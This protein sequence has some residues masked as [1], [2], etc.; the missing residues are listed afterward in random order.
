[1]S[2][3]TTVY[4]RNGRAADVYELKRYNLGKPMM[5]GEMEVRLSGIMEIGGAVRRALTRTPHC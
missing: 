5:R 2:G 4:G 1:M 3:L